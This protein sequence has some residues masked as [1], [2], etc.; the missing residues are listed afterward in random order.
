MPPTTIGVDLGGTKLLAA[1]VRDGKVGKTVKVPTP[2]AGPDAVV[3]AMAAAVKELGGADRVGIGAP[4]QIDHG[5]GVLVGAPN[6]EGF[7]HPVPI[8]SL[9]SDALAG[10][11]VR[12]DNDVNVAALGEFLHGAGRDAPDLLAVWCGTG[13]GGGIVL[14]GKVRRGNEGTAGELGH[15]TVDPNGRRC[16]CGGVGHLEA[17]AGRAALEAEARRRHDAG[18]PTKLVELAGS[19]RMKSS[20]FRKALQAGDP[21]AE[22]LLDQAVTALGVAVS[23]ATLLL[24]VGLV[25]LG[26]GLAGQLGD[27]F[28]GRVEQA[29]R[30]RKFGGLSVRVV[31]SA[32]RDDAGVVGAASLYT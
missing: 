8:A 22:D 16:A 24:D 5:S 30:A 10:T 9:V 31:A 29:I 11:E 26:G 20:V 17:Y 7:D 6:L 12:I 25:V 28:V 4:G 21:M 1:V 27:T 15:V 19:E 32:L 2:T 13:V 18:E 3:A 14:G 23:S